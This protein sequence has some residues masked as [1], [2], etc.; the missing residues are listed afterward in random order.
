MREKKER[1]NTQKDQ[2]E[3]QIKTTTIRH[4]ERQEKKERR[5]ERMKEK[6]KILG[7]GYTAKLGVARF[8]L[9]VQW[10]L[11]SSTGLNQWPALTSLDISGYFW[12][13]AVIV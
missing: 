6:R 9:S 5:K 11:I 13:S 3:G 1:K 12:Y 2:K 8:M 4:T 7:V 10:T